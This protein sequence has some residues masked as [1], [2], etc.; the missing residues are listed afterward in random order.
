MAQTAVVEHL[1]D[2]EVDEEEE[3]QIDEF[4]KLQREF[5]ETYASAHCK[6]GLNRAAA[7]RPKPKIARLKL[8]QLPRTLASPW[9]RAPKTGPIGPMTDRALQKFGS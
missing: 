2:E 7:D 3:G 6:D 9:H 1:D 5:S 4:L 8:A